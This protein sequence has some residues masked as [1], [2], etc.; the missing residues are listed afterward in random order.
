MSF[1]NSDYKTPAWLTKKLARRQVLKASAGATAIAAAPKLVLAQSS[2]IQLEQALKTDPWLSLQAVLEQL[3]PESDTGPGAK[4]LNATAYLFN[5]VNEQPIEPEEKSF[6]FKGIG[7]LNGFAQS[8]LKK[9]FVELTFDEKEKILKGISK[10][11]AGHNWLN[12]L[13]TY[14]YEAMLTP[15]SYG[16]NPDGIGWQWLDHQGGFP[17]PPKGKRFYELPGVYK[18]SVKNVTVEEKRKA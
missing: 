18:I 13:I 12:T 1:F 7:W 14:L 3:L 4:S 6:I 16:G 15:P 11:R 10:S 9:N 2:I 17:L 8:Q 5:V